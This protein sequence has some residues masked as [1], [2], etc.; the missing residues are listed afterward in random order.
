ML[1]ARATN[2]ELAGSPSDFAGKAPL[3][4]GWKLSS[5]GLDKPG[6]SLFLSFFRKIGVQLIHAI[7]KTENY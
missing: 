7:E 4:L 5:S 1:V 6:I 3:D 2:I